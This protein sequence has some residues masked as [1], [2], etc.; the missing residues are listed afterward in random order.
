MGHVNQPPTDLLKE[1]CL[2]G[3]IL[4]FVQLGVQ[5]LT[6]PKELGSWQ[7]LGRDERRIV[8]SPV[9]EEQSP[10]SQAI[11]QCRFYEGRL[12]R[13]F[14]GPGPPATSPELYATTREYCYN[15]ARR[16]RK[17]L[18]M[19]Q[20]REKS[21]KRGGIG[22]RATLVKVWS[23]NEMKAQAQQLRRIKQHIE[24]ETCS[25]LVATIK[26][27]ALEACSEFPWLEGHHRELI[28]A[29]SAGLAP[30]PDAT[31]TS[32]Q[33][34]ALCLCLSRSEVNMLPADRRP[35]VFSVVAPST[36]TSGSTFSTSTYLSG[37]SYHNSTSS[38]SCSSLYSPSFEKVAYKE[39]RLW[40]QISKQLLNQLAVAAPTACDNSPSVKS[41][42]EPS[43]HDTYTGIL[44]EESVK[45][46]LRL[47][48]EEPEDG[49]VYWIS[50]PRGSGKSTLMESIAAHMCTHRVAA[51]NDEGLKHI[52]VKL[53]SSSLSG[54][55]HQ[56]G[57]TW[58]ADLYRS[59]L[60]GVLAQNHNLV[61]LLFPREWSA[62]YCRS[63]G[64]VTSTAASNVA[65][66]MSGW[67]FDRIKAAV[68]WLFTQDA[69]PFRAC[70][71]IDGLEDFSSSTAD[72]VGRAVQ[73]STE[74]TMNRSVSTVDWS[75]NKAD[76]NRS[77][78]GRDGGSTVDSGDSDAD[79][80]VRHIIAGKWTNAKCCI[81]TEPSAAF[82]TAFA[83]RPSL[84]MA[85]LTRPAMRKFAV[86][87]LASHNPFREMRGLE[88]KLLDQ[89]VSEVVDTAN[90]V[91]LWT[92][93]A[94]STA[95][96]Q[97]GGS[98]GMQELCGRIR[99]LPRCLDD[100]YE[101]II[102]SKR[103]V[104]GQDGVRSSRLFRLVAAASTPQENDWT[105]P[106]PLPLLDLSFALEDNVAELAISTKPCFLAQQEVQQRQRATA[107]RISGVSGGLIQV[108]GGG[109][110]PARSTT[111]FI[112]DSFAAF[113]ARSDEIMEESPNLALLSAI[114]LSMKTEKV[115]ITNSR[116]NV[117]AGILYARRAEA[118]LGAH[119]SG[120]SRVTDALIE[121][122]MASRPYW[123]QLNGM[124][125]PPSHS[126][127]GD[128]GI[129]KHSFAPHCGLHQY[130]RYLMT[131]DSAESTP[132][133]HGKK[134]KQH[135]RSS[136][137]SSLFTSP[138]PSTSSS[139]LSRYNSH[140]NG[141]ETECTHLLS[142]ALQP[143]PGLGLER[144]VSPGVVRTLLACGADVS[145]A[146]RLLI[147]FLTSY[148]RGCDNRHRVLAW[149]TLLMQIL[150]MQGQ[151]HQRDI[152][153]LEAVF[154]QQQLPEAWAEIRG[155][156][157]SAAVSIRSGGVRKL[158]FVARKRRVLWMFHSAS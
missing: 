5:L 32:T 115:D 33:V 3:D 102:S 2:V 105:S 108:Q 119:H 136:S 152:Q 46:G 50:G 42:S 86:D 60:Y 124:P 117:D 36:T 40:N 118:E 17:H 113:V 8:I 15:S 19:V 92:A 123:F 64:H 96:H 125:S 74:T 81:S 140:N 147:A 47:W 23:K 142:L 69:I 68:D 135:R 76:R 112:N 51:A 70:L 21:S 106:S 88:S 49:H 79:D 4:G 31:M 11:S 18:E 20:V 59:I 61:P 111:T 25:N 14:A 143:P 80:L 114:V 7:G 120:L 90:G 71:L 39:A 151:I 139:S 10:A 87:Q 121:T 6:S 129:T 149:K 30:T 131:Q 141:D 146:A 24:E 98:G 156:L 52:V 134:K 75:R 62:A 41:D 43:Y 93:L 138:R 128:V 133:R 116:A 109:G 89:C 72:I 85:E 126:S 144:F 16:L 82:S 110:N 148:D 66:T 27:G 34:R 99:R 22:L 37:S 44:Q 145:E 12:C 26:P 65:A 73:S 9:R 35:S 104:K 155:A 38:S 122:A 100:L 29:L 150:P 78:G 107:S 157:D 137:S 56:R 97:L 63:L 94:I 48:L 54:G 95:M 158:G 13:G 103:T 154:A 132:P 130:L 57:G 153:A 53:T 77:T 84:R 28:I 91:F 55:G 127:M 45:T 67:S 58:K 1:L 101:Y 83:S